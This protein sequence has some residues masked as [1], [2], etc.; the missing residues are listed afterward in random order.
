LT[1][2]QQIDEL[3]VLTQ[4]GTMDNGIIRPDGVTSVT[5]AAAGNALCR[6]QE[7]KHGW[8]RRGL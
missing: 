4:K 6:P 8:N 3:K 7:L 2:H 5:T 1:H